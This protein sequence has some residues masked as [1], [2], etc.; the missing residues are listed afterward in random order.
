[1]YMGGLIKEVIFQEV[2]NNSETQGDG[3]TQVLGTLAGK[4][5]LSDKHKGGKVVIK[6]DEPSY[7]IGIVSLTPRIDYSQGNNWDI[8]LETMDDLH[9]PALD[10]PWFL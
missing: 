4:G 10:I 9:K 6:V 7:L 5:K 8:H 3:N 1:M 2:I